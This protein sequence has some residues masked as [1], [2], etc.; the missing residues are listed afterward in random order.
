MH[1][2]K[3]GYYADFFVYPTLLLLLGA[4][5]LHDAS[6]VAR[7]DWVGAFVAGSAGWSLVEYL[8]HRFEGRVM[9]D[10][11]RSDWRSDLLGSQR[12]MAM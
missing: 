1:L 3:V 5:G 4:S 6:P 2:S 7:M 12:P 11:C 8:A 10:P 9:E